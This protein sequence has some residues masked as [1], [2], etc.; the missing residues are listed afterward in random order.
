VGET[1]FGPAGPVRVHHIFRSAAPKP[2]KG[3]QKNM[4]G[5]AQALKLTSRAGVCNASLP[6]R[7]KKMALSNP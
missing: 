4:E 7:M 5:A 3:R 2:Y 1:G 6:K